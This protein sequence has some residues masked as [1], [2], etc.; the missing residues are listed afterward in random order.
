MTLDMLATLRLYFAIDKMAIFLKLFLIIYKY[1]KI[2]YL[3]IIYISL[4]RY[5]KLFFLC[6][7]EAHVS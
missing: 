3:N 7:L 6:Y 2:F 5:R 1:N 4:D